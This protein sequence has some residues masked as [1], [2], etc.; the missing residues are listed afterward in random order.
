MA[1]FQCAT[2]LTIAHFSMQSFGDIYLGKWKSPMSVGP[3]HNG[4]GGCSFVYRASCGAKEKIF[5]LPSSLIPAQAPTFRLGRRLRLSWWV[6]Q[7][8]GLFRVD[9]SAL[10]THSWVGWL[11]R[12][13]SR[14]AILSCCMSPSCTRSCK[15]EVRDA[16]AVCQHAE[17]CLIFMASCS[18]HSECKVVWR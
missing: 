6:R 14:H 10:M 3:W 1:V 16:C 8:L 13:L 11:C 15:E 5:R 12:S 18:G 7:L 2:L 4:F 17:W 9:E